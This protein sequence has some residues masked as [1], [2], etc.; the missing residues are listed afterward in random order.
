M[1]QANDRWAEYVGQLVASRFGGNQSSLAQALGVSGST[2]TRWIDG[3]TPTIGALRAMHEALEIPKVEL[4][5][6]A[7]ALDDGDDITITSAPAIVQDVVEAIR[8]DG[9]LLDEAKQHFLNQYELLLRVAPAKP[10]DRRGSK[11]KERPA[12]PAVRPLRAA[13]RRGRPEGS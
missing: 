8:R 11:D 5:V 7:G 6:A 12:I 9:R 1:R 13:A 10:S 2:V 4:L 3:A